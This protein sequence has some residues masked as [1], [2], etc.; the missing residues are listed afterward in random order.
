MRIALLHDYRFSIG[1]SFILAV[2]DARSVAN[3]A[4]WGEWLAFSWF[5]L[6]GIYCIQNFLSCREVHCGI[7]GPG[8]TIAAVLAL[9]HLRG[10]GTYDPLLPW[11]VFAA[12]AIVGRIVEYAHE[13][14]HGTTFVS[15]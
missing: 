13:K 9:L 14:R 11:S 3:G 7:T 15:R 2:V 6:Y 4:T 5:A 12:A 1:I 8:F 10:V